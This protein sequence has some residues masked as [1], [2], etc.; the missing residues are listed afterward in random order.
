MVTE[1]CI[2]DGDCLVVGEIFG[3]S[4]GK[5]RRVCRVKW[6]IRQNASFYYALHSVLTRFLLPI[7]E[8][9]HFI[10]IQN[11]RKSMSNPH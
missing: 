9:V 4:L 5:T 11:T 6:K 2:M 10:I 3:G 8:S 7:N 1:E